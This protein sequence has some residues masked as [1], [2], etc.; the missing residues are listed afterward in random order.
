M[1]VG[2]LNGDVSPVRI[3][4]NGLAWWRPGDV[5]RT[6]CYPDIYKYP[7]DN[8][9]CR[10]SIL[11]SG[12]TEQE[13]L[14]QIPGSEA[15]TSF[16][17]DNGEWV[18]LKTRPRTYDQNQLSVAQWYFTFKR[19]PQF[20]FF[21]VI[22]P[23]IFMSLL[24]CLVYCIPV[25]SGERISY[26]ITVLLSFAVF[27]TLIS[28]NI[29][30]TSAPM[31]LFCIYLFSVFTG[32]GM[33]MISTIYNMKLFY[34]DQSKEISPMI[35]SFTVFM[36]RKKWCQGRIIQPNGTT[37]IQVLEKSEKPGLEN[38]I[39]KKGMK[40]SKAQEPEVWSHDKVDDDITWKDVAYAV[41]RLSFFGFVVYFT[42]ATIGH[43]LVIA[44]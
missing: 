22:L 28:D 16:Y 26:A 30:K 35:R 2:T 27:M 6:S 8:Q 39:N 15:D 42:V 13:V 40:P 32:S 24:D 20:F 9:E 23:I 29:P 11:A 38:G 17:E 34:T 33:I 31:S 7:F 21:N 3:Y 43:L 12:F 10:I 4:Y 5:F 14:L 37:V 41:D 1:K 36:L 25:Q 18:L 19:R 44:L